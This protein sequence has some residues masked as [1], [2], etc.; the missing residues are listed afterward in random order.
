M[1]Y[2]VVTGWKETEF[3]RDVSTLLQQG[4]Q[5]QGGVSVA[6]NGLNQTFAQALIKIEENQ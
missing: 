2:R 5:L 4:W 1:K 3:A 6:V